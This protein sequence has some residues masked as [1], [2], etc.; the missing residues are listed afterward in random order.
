MPYQ[1][2][3]D[4]VLDAA[5][6]PDILKILPTIFSPGNRVYYGVGTSPAHAFARS[7]EI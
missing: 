5:G 1:E 4:E 3:A 7:K 6:M 2:K